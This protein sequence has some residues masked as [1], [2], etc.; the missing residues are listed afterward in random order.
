MIFLL[1]TPYYRII[2]LK[3]NLLIL[4]K[5]PFKENALITLQKYV[6]ILEQSKNILVLSKCMWCADNNFTCFGTKLYGLHVVKGI[7]TVT[8]Y[9][10]LVADSYFV[11]RATLWRLF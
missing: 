5:E 9:A 8:D 3:T 2:L 6:F 10:P 4:L 11:V 7:P 1:L